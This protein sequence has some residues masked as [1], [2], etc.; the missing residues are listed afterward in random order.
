VPPNGGD[1]DR[2]D[3]FVDVGNAVFEPL[4]H[5]PDAAEVATVEIGGQ[6]EYG[7][8]G[9]CDRFVVGPEAVERRHAARKA[10]RW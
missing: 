1:L 6:P 9:H 3:A 4:G 2:D 10:L 7:V 8:V 5:A